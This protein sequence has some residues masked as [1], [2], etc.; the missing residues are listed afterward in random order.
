[1]MRS[2]PSG[3]SARIASTDFG[4]IERESVRDGR[5]DQF[6]IALARDG[7]DHRRAAP[8]RELRGDRPDRAEHTLDE[9]WSCR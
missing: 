7:S 4:L 5:V 8:A 9:D 3:A 6:E 1:M 2:T